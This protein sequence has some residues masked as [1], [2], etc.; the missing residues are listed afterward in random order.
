MHERL[1]LVDKN[2]NPIT[3]GPREV[4]W[5]KGYYTRN[6]RVVLKDEKG[7]FL[8]QKRSTKKSSYP[9]LWT[10]AASGHVDEGET[11]E[12]AAKRE[13]E[14]EI[15]IS[16]EMKYIGG[17]NFEDD[18]GEQKI[19]QIIRVYEGIIDSSTPIKIQKEEVEITEWYENDNLKSLITTTPEI[20]TPGFLEIYERYYS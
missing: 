2:D 10:V 20:F 18:K 7:R 4:A 8:A 14:E 16:V 17:F 9:G 3:V 15:G 6:I 13:T 5:A 12:I 1:I 11:W 19:R